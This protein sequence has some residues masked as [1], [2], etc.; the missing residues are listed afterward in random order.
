MD[1]RLQV[2]LIISTFLPYSE[3][4][5]LLLNP[6]RANSRGKTCQLVA[7]GMNSLPE[8]V[9]RSEGR[10]GECARTQRLGLQPSIEAGVRLFLF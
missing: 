4:D 3:D 8:L 6:Q 1:L 10:V 2:L 9:H 7:Y 5:G